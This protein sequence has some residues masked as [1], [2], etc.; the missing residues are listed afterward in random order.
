[1]IA[2]NRL[3]K[4]LNIVVI[5]KYFLYFIKDKLNMGYDIFFYRVEQV[6]GVWEQE[7]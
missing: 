5:N 6:E 7:M 2:A 4:Y 3:I 1:M